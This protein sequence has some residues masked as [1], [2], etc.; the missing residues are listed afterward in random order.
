[1]NK[2]KGIIMTLLMV[3]SC[4]VISL[5]T[6]PLL[7]LPSTSCNPT[8]RLVVF[9]NDQDSHPLENALVTVTRQGSGVNNTKLTNSSGMVVFY[10][11]KN[12]DHEMY[13]E[14]DQ[15]YP[16]HDSF[17]FK[18]KENKTYQMVKIPD[19]SPPEISNISVNPTNST[20]SP[21]QVFNFTCKVT[22]E[23]SEINGA[24]LVL[25]S[26]FHVMTELSQD[27][28]NVTMR[29]LPAG[30]HSYYILAN[31]TDHLTSTSPVK[32]LLI[33]K[34]VTM[35]SLYLNGTE[36]NAVVRTG[37][38]LNISAI[39]TPSSCIELWKN[40]TLLQN[41]SSPIELLELFDSEGTFNIRARVSATQ[42]Y[43]SAEQNLLVTVWAD[44]DAPQFVNISHPANFTYNESV[45]C[46]FSINVTD[47][48]S[49][50]DT[51]FLFLNETKLGMVHDTDGL[52]T[53]NVSSLGAGRYQFYFFAN[54]TAGNAN[55]TSFYNFTIFKLTGSIIG[56]I[57]G[58]S[59]H[60]GTATILN[61]TAVANVSGIVNIWV[62][63]VLVSSD[64]QQAF[65]FYPVLPGTCNITFELV[66]GQNHTGTLL[67]IIIEITSPPT[68]EEYV[69]GFILL[70][71]FVALAGLAGTF[72]I[73]QKRLGIEFRG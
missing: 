13:L 4:T 24:Y 31:N 28:F 73:I 58:S 39:S 67:T 40:S 22:D 26:V 15:Y 8:A 9:V 35:L 33:E 62:N 21:N 55:Q 44:H 65:A 59:N 14:K 61:L 45:T 43:S 56:L 64:L 23:E 12:K 42:N 48:N 38:Y 29:D 18:K 19:T 6:I 37:E 3:L 63:N 72:F 16:I 17:Y 51:V 53:V 69:L 46:Q 5:I 32:E 60:T 11:A 7:F 34:N 68:G 27:Y 20:Y 47:G 1:M 57:N 10:L 30:N 2:R 71:F 52:Y 25:N 36:D 66:A 49:S 41:C 70:G 54:D 50:I